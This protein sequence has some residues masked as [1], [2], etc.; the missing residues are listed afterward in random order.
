MIPVAALV[1]LVPLIIGAVRLV[2]G[3]L[4]DEDQQQLVRW[5]NLMKEK[6]KPGE[7]SKAWQED[8]G[9]FLVNL[10]TRRGY[11]P[12][13]QYEQAIDV[14]DDL[15]TD[16]VDLLV[17]GWSAGSKWNVRALIRDPLKDRQAWHE[18]IAAG[19][20]AVI[21]GEAEDWLAKRGRSRAYSPTPA[22]RVDRDWLADSIS[23]LI[24]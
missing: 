5:A 7:P 16:L 4:P 12:A 8:V 3:L 15:L 1:E 10:T 17:G 24:G 6:P 21:L 14:P 9:Q 2:R 13:Y 18:T 22:T 23:Y 11:S 19:K 20:D